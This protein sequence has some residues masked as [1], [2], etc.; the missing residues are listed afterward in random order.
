MDPLKMPAQDAMMAAAPD[1]AK[2]LFAAYRDN[3]DYNDR[4]KIKVRIKVLLDMLSLDTVMPPLPDQ[5]R[6]VP[7]ARN[8]LGEGGAFGNIAIGN[9][10]V[11]MPRLGQD[12]QYAAPD[13]QHEGAP[14]NGNH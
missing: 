14:A 10:G 2:E 4:V 13:N 12:P 3:R 9:A 7:I 11:A 6:T 8:G 1:H 5:K